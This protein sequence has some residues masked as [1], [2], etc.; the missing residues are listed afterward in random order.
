MPTEAF[1]GLAG[2]GIFTLCLIGSM[3]LLIYAINKFC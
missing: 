1:W 3:A 2:L